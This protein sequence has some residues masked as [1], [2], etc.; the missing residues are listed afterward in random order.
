M[1]EIY[2]GVIYMVEVFLIGLIVALIGAGGY[3]YFVYS[4][5]DDRAAR[6]REI[7]GKTPWE[8]LNVDNKEKQLKKPKFT[9]GVL[10]WLVALVL[11]VLTLTL[12]LLLT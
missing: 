5:R 10:I 4:M 12:F 2:P 7:I 11:S 8:D 1:I 6:R 9:K 3:V